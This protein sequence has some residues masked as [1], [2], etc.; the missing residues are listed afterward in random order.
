MKISHQAFIGDMEINENSIIGA[1]CVSCNYSNGKR[2][3][4]IV[5]KN[6]LIGAG[7]L[8]VSPLVIGN[9]VVIGA[10]SVVLKDIKNNAKFIQ[11]RTNL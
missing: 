4:S 3:L 11:K 7:S 5:G 1:N 10:G 6:T 9:N 8:L 2:Y